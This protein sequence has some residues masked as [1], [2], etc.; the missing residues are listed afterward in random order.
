MRTSLAAS[1]SQRADAGG[2]SDCNRHPGRQYRWQQHR[3]RQEQYSRRER[4]CKCRTSGDESEDCRCYAGDPVALPN[5]A[6]RGTDDMM[7]EVVVDYTSLAA[8]A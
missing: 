4:V 3:W 1:G 7:R 2:V 8:A 5:A 6:S